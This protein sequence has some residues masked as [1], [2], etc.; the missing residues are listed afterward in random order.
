MHSGHRRPKLVENVIRIVNGIDETWSMRFSIYENL[1]SD[2]AYL[3]S[4]IV[5]SA[6]QFTLEGVG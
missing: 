2:D 1:V 4:S 6:G 5:N 3:G